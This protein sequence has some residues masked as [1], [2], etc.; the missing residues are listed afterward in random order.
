LQDLRIMH[1]NS[2]ILTGGT[3]VGEFGVDNITAA[4]APGGAAMLL[5]AFGLTSRRKRGRAA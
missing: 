1:A 5:V 2:P 4:P 3:L